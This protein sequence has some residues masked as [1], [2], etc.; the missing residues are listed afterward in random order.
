MLPLKKVWDILIKNNPG[1]SNFSHSKEQRIKEMISV[2]EA[3][4]I[5]RNNTKALSEQMFLLKDAAGLTLAEDVYAKNDFPSFDQSAMDGYAFR[6]D[7]WNGEPL[8]IT[9]E[10]QAGATEKINTEKNQAVRIFTG[11]PVPKKFDTVVMQEKVVAENNRLTILDDGLK[12]GANVRPQGSEMGNGLLALEKG[13]LLIPGAIGFIAGLGKKEIKAIRKPLVSIIVTGKELQT[14]S[15]P[16]RY[17]QVYESNSYALTAALQQAGILNVTTHWVDDDLKML[18]DII[19]K[20]LSSADLLLLTGGVS[21][22]D[23]DFVSEA[24]EQSGVE[25]LFHKIKQKPGKP[26]LFGK[27]EEKIVFGLPGNPS[28]VLT[29]FYEYVLIAIQEMMGIK[30]PFLKTAQLPMACSYSKKAGLMHFLKGRQINNEVLA[31][32]AQE[33]YRMKS[34]ALAD[35]LIVL[36]ENKTEMKKGELAEVHFLY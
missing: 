33:S 6:F 22:G 30:K 28:S 11:A 16:L 36:E 20:E 25:K 35:C 7:E 17:G 1:Q 32:D 5:I 29:C 24:L 8:Q 27:K 15:E 18:T 14:P 23:Y 21:V 19:K 3:K 2:K 4:D 31:L 12:K 13:T 34:F 10:V 26:L 9:G